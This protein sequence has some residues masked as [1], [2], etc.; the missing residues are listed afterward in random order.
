MFEHS[1]YLTNTKKRPQSHGNCEIRGMEKEK[2]RKQK[3]FSQSG[4]IQSQD[5][6]KK[7]FCFSL[8][9]KGGQ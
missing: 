2:G 8:R 5:I 4:K 7:N 6:N 3:D 9:L 1:P